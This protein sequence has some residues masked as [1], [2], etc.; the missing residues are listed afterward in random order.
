MGANASLRIDDLR[1]G[2]TNTVLIGEIRAGMIPQDPRG[3]WA[4]SGACPSALWAHGYINDDNG[5]NY[6]GRYGD[7][8]PT[9]SEAEAAAGGAAQLIQLGMSCAGSFP[10][11]QQTA[12]SLHSGGVNVCLADGS[13]RFI[14]DFVELGTSG[15]PPQCLGLWD[16]LN[17]SRDGSPIDASR[18]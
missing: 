13:V 18:F 14:S 12:R 15:T 6:N 2:T 9:C 11:T 8:T 3:V 10:N 16:K 1:D 7:D 17:L 5:P 4:M